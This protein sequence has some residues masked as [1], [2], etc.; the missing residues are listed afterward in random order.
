M[1]R[2][3]TASRLHFGLFRVAPP[4]QPET[5]GNRRFG[6][7]GLMV[8]APGLSLTVHP[9]VSWSAEGPHA[10]RALV[11]AQRFVETLPA[12]VSSPQRLVVERAPP[13]HAGLGTG[14][15]LGLAVARALAIAAGRPDLDAPELARRVG[16]GERS[17]LGV[18]GFA[19]GGF[20][21]EAGKCGSEAVAPLVARMEIPDSWRLVLALPPGPPGFHGLA[22]RQAFQQLADRGQSESQTDAQCRLVLLNLLPAVAE[23]DLT[24]FGEA[25][26]EFNARAGESFAAIQGGRYASPRVAELVSFLRREG[27]RGV[28]QSSWGPAVFA[29][30]VDEEHANSLVG[31]LR[32]RFALTASDVFVTRA[33]NHAASVVENPVD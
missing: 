27:I 6:G 20:L 2:V 32:A 21:V 23:R 10:E 25:L 24:D 26:H 22:E 29:V 7:V 18:H 8:D 4:A 9:A 30:T 28:G 16:R 13:A 15:Q 33:C 31:R 17:A 3:T 5:P 1:T 14:T 11:F 19:L 12:A